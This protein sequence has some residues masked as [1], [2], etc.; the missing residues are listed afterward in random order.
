MPPRSSPPAA[1]AAIEVRE[2]NGEK[3]LSLSDRTLVFRDG[4]LASLRRGDTEYLAAGPRIQ[5]WR[6][7]IDND[8]I[9][10]WSS[11]ATSRW[12]NGSA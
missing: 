10:L 2:K 6:G 1:N 7:A 8:G 12:A 5:L 9:K 3:S 11:Q 4:S